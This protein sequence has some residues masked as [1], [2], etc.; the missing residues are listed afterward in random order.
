MAFFLLNSRFSPFPSSSLSLLCVIAGPG[1]WL[2]GVQ[3]TLITHLVY[4]LH[5]YIL[6]TCFIFLPGCRQPQQLLIFL[7]SQYLMFWINTILVILFFLF[8]VCQHMFFS[9]TH[10]ESVKN[11][12]SCLYLAL[13]TAQSGMFWIIPKFWFWP[14]LSTTLQINPSF[15]IWIFDLSVQ[16]FGFLPPCLTEIVWHLGIHWFVS[17][18]GIGWEYPQLSTSTA[19]TK[20]RRETIGLFLCKR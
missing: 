14:A 11:L 15:W 6:P 17:L 4:C 16:F 20:T 13:L 18:P 9:E 2:P 8:L 3:L 7:L 5:I 12:G 1:A 19:S 10:S